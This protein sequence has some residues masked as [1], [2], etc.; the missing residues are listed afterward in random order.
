ME[1][2]VIIIIVI[3][4]V[5]VAW[6]LGLRDKLRAKKLFL[7]AVTEKYGHAPQKKYRDD[8]FDH[9]TGYYRNHQ[10]GFRIDD[11]TWN[12]LNMDSVFK[13]MNYCYSA[14]G[15]EY[16][17]Y[18]LRTPKLSDDFDDFEKQVTF[19]KENDEFRRKLQLGFYNIGK[20]SR[21][22][23]Y[24]YLDYLSQVKHTSN[25]IHYLMLLLMAAAIVLLFVN[26]PVGFLLL[27]VLMAVQIVSYFRIKSDIEP[28]LVTYHY[29]MRVIMSV[30]NII[31]IKEDVFS[32]E[33]EELKSLK[34]EFASFKAGAF[35]LMSSNRMNS[36]GNPVDILLDYIRMT[37]HLDII[38]FNQMFRQLMEKSAK[39]DRMLT[40]I[41]G[42]DAEVSVACFRASFEG[43]YAVPTFE[44]DT[45]RG[46]AL[47]HPLLDDAV[48]NDIDAAKGV[49][50]TGSNASGKSTFLKTCAINAVLAQSVHTVLGQSYTAPFYRTYSSMA[51]K[52]NIFEGDSY[53][54]VEIKSIKRIIDATEDGE[55]K[56]LCFVDEVLRGT[57]TVER[58]AASTQILKKLAEENV[59]CFA[60]THDI[61]LTALLDDD[62]DIY[63]FEGDIKENDVRFDYK[64]KK[65]PATTR[66][67]IQLLAALGYD[68]RIVN[69]AQK[70]ADKFLKTGSWEK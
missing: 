26:F 3:A 34:K 6:L 67:A 50:L 8:D 32:K 5:L 27:L 56:V 48:D 10:D 44:G 47:I 1:A 13:R 29:V 63:H 46:K 41:G 22:S 60:A 25:G 42:M 65:G 64:I 30:D 31:G 14:A 61:E 49:L 7:E 18:M 68:D 59:L 4:F 69:D 12:D 20:S 40:V 55:A 39:L 43:K 38:K 21:Y 57:N 16:L 35:I 54:I 24:D 23:I 28:F 45:Y 36:G 9:L 2:Y 17:Y 66:N 52:D 33:V 37:T 51:L 58:I 70:M 62:Y 19:I 11:I 53:Y 15:E